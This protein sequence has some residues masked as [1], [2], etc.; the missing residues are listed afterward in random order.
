M[1]QIYIPPSATT[2][3]VTVQQVEQMIDTVVEGY[4]PISG[5]NLTGDLNGV[6]PTQITYSDTLTSNIQTQINT[7]SSDLGNYLPVSSVSPNQVVQTNGSSDAISSN[8]LPTGVIMS[9]PVISDYAQF[10]ALA[11][12][13]I[14]QTDANKHT[15]TSNTLPNGTSCTNPTFN[16][17][18]LNDTITTQLTASAIVQTNSGSQLSAS[19]IL[20]SGCTIPNPILSSISSAQGTSLLQINGSNQIVE[21]NELPI[22]STLNNPYVANIPSGTANEMIMVSSGNEII[23]STT[24]PSSLTYPTPTLS[25]AVT[26]TDINDGNPGL[27]TVLN[28]GNGGGS[29][30]ETW[31]I[32]FDPNH[33]SNQIGSTSSPLPPQV[34]TIDIGSARCYDNGSTSASTNIYGYFYQGSTQI[35]SGYSGI[36]TITKLAGTSSGTATVT[37]SSIG[38]NNS[39]IPI[40]TNGLNTENNTN[41]G[42]LSISMRIYWYISQ[43]PARIVIE[44]TAIGY[45][46]V[47]MCQQRTTCYY[48]NNTVSDVSSITAI[49]LYLSNGSTTLYWGG[50]NCQPVVTMYHG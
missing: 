39:Y 27:H 6:T 20:P 50:D 2:T 34:V 21:Y 32:Y 22:G 18:T 49:G 19:N 14:L 46:G 7:L 31:M 1:S 24:L 28:P 40:Y 12:N 42:A 47:D 36:T 4:L 3:S 13:S 5:G 44:S 35:N 33:T 48:L 9:E 17:P 15:I 41:P 8:T 37:A 25:G 11:I 38:N 16:Y 10:G 29:T 23:T 45:D 26:M 30:N 43:G